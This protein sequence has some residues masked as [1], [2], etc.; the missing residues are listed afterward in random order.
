MKAKDDI[1]KIAEKEFKDH[2]LD[3]LMPHFNSEST[4]G[5]WRCRK[6]GTGIYSFT[7]AIMP[8]GFITIAGDVGD[9]VLR[10]NEKTAYGVIAW[11][12]G[13]VDSP[14]YLIS[15]AQP[16]CRDKMTAFSVEA[17]KEHLK[18]MEEEEPEK[19][20]NIRELWINSD[21]GEDSEEEWHEAYYAGTGDSEVPRCH[22]FTPDALWAIE[23]LRL[24][25]KLVAEAPENPSLGESL[26]KVKP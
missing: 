22:E 20:N 17:A 5:M 6:P 7:V 3:E 23:C 25:A 16:V 21:F 18:W 12:R 19:A 9:I 11:I 10:C 2:V 13:A 24:F 15:K 14:D 4:A 26:E 1:K 8:G